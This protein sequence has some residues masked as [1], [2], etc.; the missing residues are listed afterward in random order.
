MWRAT[1]GAIRVSIA[2]Y[3]RVWSTLFFVLLDQ[4]GRFGVTLI[5]KRLGDVRLYCLH[6]P[7]GPIALL[8]FIG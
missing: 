7:V 4:F 1:R 6:Y 3:G 5:G 8:L 2:P